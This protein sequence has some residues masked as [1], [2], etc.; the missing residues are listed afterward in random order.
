MSRSMKNLLSFNVLLYVLVSSTVHTSESN[1]ETMDGQATSSGRFRQLTKQL[2]IWEGQ[3]EPKPAPA[4]LFT[5][6]PPVLKKNKTDICLNFSR[7]LSSTLRFRF[8]RTG[9]GYCQR[10][11][12]N[13]KRFREK[14]TPEFTPFGSSLRGSWIFNRND[15]T[16]T[17]PMDGVSEQ[18]STN[19]GV[20]DPL[21]EPFAEVAKMAID[22]M[23]RERI[24]I[25][26]QIEFLC[27]IKQHLDQK[28]QEKMLNESE[29]MHR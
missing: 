21:H 17:I 20:D 14:S 6:K 16:N 8:G 4:P 13:I 27:K 18:R 3:P 2:G 11:F 1:N 22:Q 12:D 29:T 28:I 5:P 9:T 23:M 26:E 19:T 7:Q 25:S 15:S 10:F 24:E